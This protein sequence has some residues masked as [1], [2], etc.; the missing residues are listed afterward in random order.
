MTKQDVLKRMKNDNVVLVELQFSDVYGRVKSLTTTPAQMEDVFDH[1]IWFDGSSVEGFARIYESDMVLKP[2]VKTYAILPWW[3][4]NG[5]GAVC[6]F[7]CDVELPKGEPF[8]GDPRTILKR[9]LEKASAK[10]YQ[11]NVGPE[12]EFF[13]FKKDEHGRVMRRSSGNGDYFVLS[14]D[15]AYDIKRDIIRA[16]SSFNITVEMSHYEVANNQHEIDFR[17]GDALTAADN[18]MTLKFAVKK[19]ASEHGYYATFLPKPIYGVNGSGMHVHQSLFKKGKNAF[20]DTKDTYGLSRI[21]YQFIAGQL[22]HVREISALVAPTVN[23]YKRLTPGFEAPVYVC[24]ARKN[25]SALIRIPE[26]SAGREQA[27]RAELRCPDG[28]SN[29]YLAFAAMLH[30]GL[31][32]IEAKLEP[33]APV[34]EDVYEFDDAK[35]QR[36]YINKL[37]ASLD[38]ALGEYEKSALCRQTLGDHGYESFLELKRSEWDSFRTQVTDWEMKRYFDVF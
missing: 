20:S 15:E 26:I 30:A 17:Y 33:P 19:I 11:Y 22:A 8:S 6:R 25:R 18:V 2:D 35:L 23:S 24:W 31:A 37:P 28:S 10:G 9:A 1:G 36:Y 5:S 34:E 4:G 27:T 29:P 3:S 38:E 16:L 21:A 13:L 12:L 32:G 7:I 14:M